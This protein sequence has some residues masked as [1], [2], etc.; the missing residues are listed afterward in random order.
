MLNRSPSSW[1]VAAAGGAYEPGALLLVLLPLREERENGPGSWSARAPARVDASFL[2]A[3]ADVPPAQ[4]ISASLALWEELNWGEVVKPLI[5][6]A[7]LRR[8]GGYAGEVLGL[9]DARITSHRPFGRL[10]HRPRVAPGATIWGIDHVATALHEQHVLASAAIPAVF[11]AVRGARAAH[12]PGLV[13]RRRHA[14]EHARSSRRLHWARPESSSSR[15]NPL[16]PGRS[17]QLAARDDRTRS[18]ARPRSRSG[19]SGPALGCALTLASI[20]QLLVATR[21]VTA[22][23]KRRVPNIRVAPSE[24][25]LDRPAGAQVIREHYSGA[26]QAIGAPDLALL[27]RLTA[28]DRDTAHAALLSFLLFAS[29]F[30]KALITLGREGMRSGRQRDFDPDDR[31]QRRAITRSVYGSRSLRRVRD[32]RLAGL[33]DG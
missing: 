11:P 26:L 25:R 7:S 23:G 19:F 27:P 28:A 2:A 8:L 1:R 20:N 21:R 18:R 16:A 10:S 6:A 33:R 29:E 9:P 14:P 17:P 13:F 3:S 31:N 15:S 5:S 24:P 22:A 32:L 12:G 4:L 30:A